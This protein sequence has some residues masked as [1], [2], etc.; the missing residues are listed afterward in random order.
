V[1]EQLTAPPAPRQGVGR[2]AA[3]AADPAPDR[4]AAGTPRP[5]G[6]V[7]HDLTADPRLS[8]TAVRVAALLLYWARAKDHCWP[9]DASI[10]AKAGRSV[11]TVQR[12]LKSLE[13]AGWIAREKTTANR[14][15]R[16]IRLAWRSA[17]ARPP[18]SSAPDPP[19]PSALDEGEAGER[20]AGNTPDAALLDRLKA[21]GLPDPL[22][23]RFA[24]GERAE[25]ARR[26]LANVAVLKAR[27]RLTN[28]AGYI[29]AGVEA[30]YPLLPAAAAR[31]EAGRRAAD[32]AA[33]NAA[34]ALGRALAE[35]E[36]MAEARAEDAALAA[37]DPR[38]LAG[39]VATALAELPPP[40][41]RR[42]PTLA[43]P[44]IRARVVEWAAAS[45]PTG[46]ATPASVSS[47]R[48]EPGRAVNHPD[49]QPGLAAPRPRGPTHHSKPA[50]LHNTAAGDAA[51]ISPGPQRQRDGVAYG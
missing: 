41:T 26:V 10:G 33:R 25:A 35:A 28:P 24:R 18:A 48:T 32:D 51:R 2:I 8:A 50:R 17:G 45:A 34:A 31:L 21:E 16:I 20:D 40:L 43:N 44:F 22:A 23:R 29:R 15:G 9:A 13:A 14:T 42:D 47:S 38:R 7:P 1:S 3:R 4:R 6:A 39:L 49:G 36:R 5:Y 46:A 30:G 37:T 19:A 27:G 11:G 12:A